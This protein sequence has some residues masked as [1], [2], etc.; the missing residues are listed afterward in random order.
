MTMTPWGRAD[1]LRE[2]K[3]SPGPG[4]AR[5]VVERSQRERLMGATVA[6]VAEKGYAATRVADLLE[7]SGV[8]RNAFYK[9]FENKQQCFL[10]TLEGVAQATGEVVMDAY[11]SAEGSWDERLGSAFETLAK[12]CVVQ[13]A[14][15]R[16]G[17]VEVYAA[18]P[19]AL[20]Y[21]EAIDARIMRVIHHALKE[22]PERA[23]MPR[24]VL[25]AILGGLRKIMH[26][27]LREGRERELPAL[28]P[29]LLEWALS[30]R[31]PSQRLKRPRKPPAALAAKRPAPDD[32]RARILYAV[33]DLVAEKGYPDMA[34][35][36]IADRARVSLSTFYVHFKG[37]EDA[38]LA[39]LADAQ[40]RVLEATLPYYLAAGDWPHAISAASRAFFGF[41][42]TEPTTAQL[43]GVGVW[44]TG[45]AALDQ[46][47]QGMAGF[48]AQLDEGYRQYPGAGLVAAEAIG[49][50]VD[51]LLYAQLRAKGAERLYEIA[52]AAA[53]IALAP[54]VGSEDASVLANAE[55]P[56]V[57]T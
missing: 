18:G 4:T 9:L 19:E 36:E 3:L 17:L 31:T 47:A 8:S 29:G 54:F 13:P 48:G 26:T 52:T 12:L 32:S 23:E 21:L 33:T 15:A 5:P 44:A 40:R 14:A 11:T 2:R 53:F 55:P 10:A 34:I 30:Y 42:A 56:K 39:T 16:I 28:V 51:A 1:E 43:G 45:P 24:E 7:V 6:V 49:A 35:T 46:R 57:T 41:L 38:F 22:S 50:S 27:R 37:K 25:V 20:E